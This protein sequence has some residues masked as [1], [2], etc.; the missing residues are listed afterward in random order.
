MK[1]KPVSPRSPLHL[2]DSDARVRSIM[3]NEA[4]LDAEIDKQQERIKA[5]QRIFAADARHALL[6]VLQGRDASGKDGIIRH[7]I[8]AIDPQGCEVTGFKEP[9][10]LELRHDFLW[11]VH[12]H[13]PALGMVGIFNRSHYEDVIVARVRRLVPKESWQSRFAQINAFEHMLTENG[14]VILKF[15]LHISRAEQK[16]RLQERLADKTKNWKF[17]AG[18]LDDRTRWG[19]YTVAFT[20]AMQRC[21]TA[22]AP[23]FVVPADEKPVRNLLIA[24]VIADTLDRL[25]LRYPPV[26][27][28]VSSL[29]IR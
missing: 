25:G 1:L 15:F 19:A 3:P 2:R 11:R 12:Q 21:S 20:E 4:T 18:D 7:V 17:R 29:R 8:T 10:A 6:I 23:W 27:R 5:W 13:I 22:W 14:V 24:R 28:A 9:S 26:D 16:R